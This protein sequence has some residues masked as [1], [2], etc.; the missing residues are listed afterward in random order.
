MRAR[1]PAALVVENTSVAQPQRTVTAE[2]YR[3]RDALLGLSNIAVAVP[4][5]RRR[6]TDVAQLHR[7][8]DRR[9][10]RG[11]LLFRHVDQSD[12]EEILLQ[13]CDAAVC[14]NVELLSAQRTRQDLA[15][16][17]L[18]VAGFRRRGFETLPAESVNARQR[19]RIVEGLPADAAL[20]DVPE[21]VP[22][23]RQTALSSSRSH[24]SGFVFSIIPERL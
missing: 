3:R 17:R 8:M 22:D 18:V 14:R 9:C 24:F 15:F 7:R 1:Q 2:Q 11:V 19:S 6:R 20:R 23:L 16:R 13:S 4:L 12:H 5:G 21:I 10:S